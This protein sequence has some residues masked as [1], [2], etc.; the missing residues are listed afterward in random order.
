MIWR[1]LSKQRRTQENQS[2]LDSFV[3]RAAKNNSKNNGY[4]HKIHQIFMMKLF[5]SRYNF[6]LE[7]S[8]H[9]GSDSN[10]SL[11]IG[12]NNATDCS[13]ET[14][15]TSVSLIKKRFGHLAVLENLSF[16]SP[17]KNRAV[18]FFKGQCFGLYHIVMP[19]LLMQQLSI[20]FGLI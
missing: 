3:K 10:Y 12:E 15:L 18:K 20:Y 8:T 17:R 11:F 16:R 14:V 9:F 19:L 1:V 5:C 7:N 2:N 4:R 6:C 13:V